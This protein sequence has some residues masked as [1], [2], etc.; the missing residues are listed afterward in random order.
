MGC[1]GRLLGDGVEL[2]GELF[3]RVFWGVFYLD[4]K[5]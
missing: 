1:V 2:M 5:L 3:W 4:K